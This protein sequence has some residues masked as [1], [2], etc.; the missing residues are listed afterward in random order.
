[1]QLESL[2]IVQSFHILFQNLLI[3]YLERNRSVLPIINTLID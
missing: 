3:K 2:S 1:M